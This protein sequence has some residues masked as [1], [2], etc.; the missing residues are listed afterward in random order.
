MFDPDETVLRLYS[1]LGYH[2]A[3]PPGPGALVRAAFGRGA[4]CHS[5]DV[6]HGEAQIRII[7]GRKRVVVRPNMP[8]AT[9]AAAYSLALAR[10]CTVR[11]N[12]FIGAGLIADLGRRIHVPSLALAAYR[13]SGIGPHETAILLVAEPRLVQL[14]WRETFSRSGLRRVG[15]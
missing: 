1:D 14:R 5:L 15:G 8:R 2:P 4:T 13:L 6:P 12:L 9:L 7:E 3:F 10:W 11:E